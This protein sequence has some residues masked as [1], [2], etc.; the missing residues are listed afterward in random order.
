M[1]DN[2]PLERHQMLRELV[3]TTISSVPPVYTTAEIDKVQELAELHITRSSVRKVP[4]D[5]TLAIRI[6]IAGNGADFLIIT[7]VEE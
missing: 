1:V 4:D 7:P 2:A 6:W 3:L 5:G